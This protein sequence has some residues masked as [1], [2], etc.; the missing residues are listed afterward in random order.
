MGDTD[1]E[2][3][4]NEDSSEQDVNELTKEPDEET[5]ASEE[6]T[7]A[8]RQTFFRARKFSKSPVAAYQISPGSEWS[9]EEADEEIKKFLTRLAGDRDLVEARDP[10]KFAQE[11]DLLLLFGPDEEEEFARLALR[12]PEET[13]KNWATL[14]SGGS[15]SEAFGPRSRAERRSEAAVASE[16]QSAV[17]RRLIAAGIGVGVILVIFFGL[18]SLTG[19]TDEKVGL[20]LRFSEVSSVESI[21]SN[22]SSYLNFFNPITE[23]ALVA[24]ADRIV[25]VQQGEGQLMERI[26]VDVPYESLPIQPGVLSATV[27]QYREG[28][29]ALVGPEDWVSGSCI[30]VSVTT[31]N[32][33]PLDV[34]HYAGSE[35]YCPS[36]IK[37]IEVTPTC[38]GSS[39]LIL[40]IAI[41][42]RSDPQKLPEGGVG[43]AEKVRF[44]IES[45]T[46]ES[47]GW[48]VLS[49]RG[50]IE[51]PEGVEN[52]VIPKFGGAPGDQLEID[53][54][55]GSEGPIT[56]SCIIE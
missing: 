33:R 14:L 29:I 22:N 8:R 41:P 37:G 31:S 19:N 7:R 20:G 39:A 16:L 9:P 32:L 28:Q 30:M 56:G 38:L 48:E 2:N 43:W 1:S 55:M 11:N 42:Q 25:A 47:D 4:L 50:T 13:V 40:P 45:P 36:R 5:G 3:E 35:T 49:V 53:L 17:F 6:E 23:P 15:R 46:A 10:V 52:V 21:E 51:V 12:F 24:V 34:L 27:F 18:K 44:T 54:G 26:K